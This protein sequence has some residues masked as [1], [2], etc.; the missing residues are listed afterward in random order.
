VVRFRPAATATFVPCCLQQD[1]GP[2][3]RQPGDSQKR[4]GS[5]A[6]VRIFFRPTDPPGSAIVAALKVNDR[7]A[8]SGRTLI[9]DGPAFDVAGRGAVWEARA[10]EVR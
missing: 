8:V 6:N 2:T 4:R 1:G 7:F 9:L 10:R 3:P 5:D